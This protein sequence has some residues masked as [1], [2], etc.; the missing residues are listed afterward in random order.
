M[1]VW[2]NIIIMNNNRTHTTQ[3][4]QKVILNDHLCGNLKSQ[5]ILGWSDIKTIHS[6]TLTPQGLKKMQSY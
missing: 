4:Q 2:N 5:D 1:T 3:T 6:I